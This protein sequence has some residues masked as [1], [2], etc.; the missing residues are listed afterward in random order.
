M[1]K[2]FRHGAGGEGN[3]VVA[4]SI[5]SCKRRIDGEVVRA[6]LPPQDISP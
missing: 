4:R 1:P 6:Y 2:R 3:L 5:I